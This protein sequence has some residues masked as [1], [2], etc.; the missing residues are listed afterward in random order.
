M[1]IKSDLLFCEMLNVYIKALTVNAMKA[2]K[3]S[4]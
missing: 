2:L 3:I 1:Q 4:D